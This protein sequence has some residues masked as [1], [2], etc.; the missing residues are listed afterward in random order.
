[1]GYFYGIELANGGEAFTDDQCEWLHPQVPLQAAA[2]ARPALP[3]RR[4]WRP[5]DPAVA[6]AG[7]GPRGVRGHHR[8]HPPGPHR[9]VEGAGTGD[10]DRRGRRRDRARRGRQGRSSRPSRPTAGCP[11]PSS[12]PRSGCRRRRCASGSSGC[13]TG[14]S[15]RSWPSPTRPGSAS[16]SRP[17]SASP[18]TAT[19]GPSPTPSPSGRRI[20]YVVVTAG[21]FD[22]FVE[23][24]AAD[25]AAPAR[26]RHDRD[27]RRPRR[28]L[29]RDLHLPRAR[30]ADLRLGHPLG[31]RRSGLA[32]V[33]G[34]GAGDDDRRWRRA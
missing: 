25:A 23:V 5:G 12:G 18:S 8:H 15:C 27:P 10:L 14:A 20:D 3:G 24:V 9:G 7:V 17:S 4:P 30:Q 19:P 13:S 26:P 6:P 28:D 16:A 29:H 21:R 33:P 34:E 22:I 2:R 1:M 31:P 32:A 11:T